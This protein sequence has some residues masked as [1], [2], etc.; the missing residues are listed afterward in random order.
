VLAG[1]AWAQIPFVP[2]GWSVRNMGMGMT[3]TGV[4][5][6]AAAWY[7]NPAGLAN[8]DVTPREGKD[9]GH[10]I[11][12]SYISLG[13]PKSSPAEHID[14]IRVSW[15]TCNP[16]D[17]VGVGAGYL[18]MD[19]PFSFGLSTVGA[20]AGIGI[21]NTGISV[22]VNVININPSAPFPISDETLLGLGAMYSVPMGGRSP[23]RLGLTYTNVTE[24]GFWP[25]TLN[26]GASWAITNNITVAADVLDILEDVQDTFGPG[27]PGIHWNAG[28]ELAF[29][30]NRQFAVRGGLFDLDVSSIDM[31]WT[32]GAGFRFGRYRVDGAYVSELSGSG[33]P[34]FNATWTVGAGMVF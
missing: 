14:T 3:G 33:V 12:A 32:L 1:T 20:G 10:D 6:G 31:F 2:V 18:N 25:S 11:E 9:W 24:E 27:A 16:E 22:G 30:R 26:A 23:I 19:L 7:Q 5:D 29:G 34:P 21:G 17:N 15:S 13:G 28:G 8:L 4:A